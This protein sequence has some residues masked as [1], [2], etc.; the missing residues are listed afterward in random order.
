MDM[1]H[2]LKKKYVKTILGVSAGLVFGAVYYRLVGCKT[3]SCPLTSTVFRSMAYGGLMGFLVS[4]MF[5]P[6]PS[7]QTKTTRE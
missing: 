5:T 6:S 2:I 7:K 3:G 1:K 4:Q